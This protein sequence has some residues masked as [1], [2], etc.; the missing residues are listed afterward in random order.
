VPSPSG[1]AGDSSL[2]SVWARTAGDAWAVGEA[3]D[4][5]LVEHWDGESWQ[6][7]PSPNGSKPSSALESV[8]GVGP[9]DVWAVGVSYDDIRVVYRTLTEH[10]DGTAWRV[11]PSPNPSSEYDFLQAVASVAGGSVWTAGAADID[12]LTMRAG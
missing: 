6:I 7:V 3:A 5:T 11:V 4:A 10:W 9:N 12:T 2:L 8:S 1:P